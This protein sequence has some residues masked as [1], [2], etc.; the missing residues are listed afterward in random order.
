MRGS[1]AARRG[2]VVP[3]G[4]FAALVDILLASIGIFVIIFAL[5]EIVEEV[6]LEPL[7]YSALVLCDGQ[8]SLSLALPE[9][10]VAVESISVLSGLLAERLPDGGAIFFGLALPCQTQAAR[11]GVSFAMA[12]REEREALVAMNEAAPVHLFEVGPIMADEGAAEAFAT[13]W[14]SGGRLQDAD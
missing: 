7:D 10:T 3:A 12:L 14:R 11:P 5:Q 1:M 8:T 2:D 4:G 9:E 13:S 6:P